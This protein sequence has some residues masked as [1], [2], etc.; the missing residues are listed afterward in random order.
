MPRELLTANVYPM[1]MKDSTERNL[2]TNKFNSP[3]VALSASLSESDRVNAALTSGGDV[4]AILLAKS[5]CGE[6][7]WKKYVMECAIRLLSTMANDMSPNTKADNP[8]MSKHDIDIDMLN[9]IRHIAGLLQYMSNCTSWC[10]DT[11]QPYDK[12]EVKKRLAQASIL[13]R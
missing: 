12:Q 9:Q 2:D 4:H 11:Y 3:I 10:S 13:G 7:N 8:T 5:E 6:T 1:Y